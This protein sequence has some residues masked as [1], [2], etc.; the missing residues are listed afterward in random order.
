MAYRSPRDLA[1]SMAR[2]RKAAAADDGYVRETFTQDREVARQTA[3]AFLDR[4]PAAAYMSADDR[5]RELPGDRI[6][7]TMRRLKSAD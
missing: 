4:W 6:E 1:D 2:R 7:F 5:W 3:R